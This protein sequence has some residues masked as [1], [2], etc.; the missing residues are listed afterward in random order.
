[1]FVAWRP[2]KGL[3]AIYHA[4]RPAKGRRLAE[5]IIAR[6]PSCPIPE[7]A[8]LGRTLKKW[9]RKFLA[10]F[11]TAGASNDGTE[12]V[13][14]AIE[15]DRRVARGFRNRD[16]YRLRML[17]IG[18]GVTGPTSGKESRVRRVSLECSRGTQAEGS[19]FPEH[20]TP[21][22]CACRAS[23]PTRARLNQEC[24]AIEVPRP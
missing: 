20:E 23:P 22:H 19:G 9:R 4:T 12:A 24:L 8:R 5:Q 3:W 15:L 10:Y 14:G 18:D 11:D 17:L 2:A 6:V 16:T 1:M 7:V 21:H 13:N